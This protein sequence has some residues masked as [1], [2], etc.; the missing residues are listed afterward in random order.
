MA[1]SLR[2]EVTGQF[3]NHSLVLGWAGH[4]RMQWRRETERGA[5]EPVSKRKTLMLDGEA[6]P[7]S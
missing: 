6:I 7:V 3:T 5:R 4:N 2:V 1:H